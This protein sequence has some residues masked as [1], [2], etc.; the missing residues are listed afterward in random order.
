LIVI[1]TGGHLGY[2]PSKGGKQSTVEASRGAE[3]TWD[4]SRITTQMSQFPLGQRCLSFRLQRETVTDPVDPIAPVDVPRDITVGHK[5][6]AWA[7]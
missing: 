1:P 7:R 3:K 5:R 4:V 2:Y 6:P